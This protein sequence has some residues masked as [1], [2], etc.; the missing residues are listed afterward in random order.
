MLLFCNKYCHVIFSSG[1]PAVIVGLVAAIRPVSFDMSKPSTVDVTCGSL[2]LTARAKRNRCGD[3][4]NTVKS[5]M[6]CIGKFAKI[7][8][9]ANCNMGSLK[10][11]NIYRNMGHCSLHT[12]IIHARSACDNSAS[13]RITAPHQNLHWIVQFH[14]CVPIAHFTVKGGNEAGVDLVLIQ[15]FLLYYV[16]HIVVMLTSSFKQNLRKRREV[17]IKTRSTSASRSLK[18]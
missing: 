18:G 7:T 11:A 3:N 4:L 13:R 5:P 2:H 1:I 6:L 10:I 15:P 17:C 16:N 12:A 8:T 9:Q 14:I